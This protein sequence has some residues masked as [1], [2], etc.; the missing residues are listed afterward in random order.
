MLLP[1]LLLTE[2]SSIKIVQNSAACLRIPYK[3]SAMAVEYTRFCQALI[4]PFCSSLIFLLYTEY[5][6]VVCFAYN[7]NYFAHTIFL[8]QQSS[9]LN[10][11]FN[12]MQSLFEVRYRTL[13]DWSSFRLD[14][15]AFVYS[16]AILLTWLK[17]KN[18]IAAMVTLGPSII[19]IAGA[20]VVAVLVKSFC[21]PVWQD[22][23][24]IQQLARSTCSMLYPDNNHVIMLGGQKVIV[25]FIIICRDHIIMMVI[26]KKSWK[27]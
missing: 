18:Y 25:S 7:P 24:S 11:P 4:N 27:A 23:L 13:I 12:P 21:P 2:K 5:P 3:V 9:L 16:P 14:Y 26:S 1:L 8:K 22:F 15:N 6:L 20:T 10:F 19:C 17:L